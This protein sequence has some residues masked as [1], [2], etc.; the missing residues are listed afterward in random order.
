MTKMDKDA[1]ELFNWKADNYIND[2]ESFKIIPEVC[3]SNIMTDTKLKDFD[4]SFY[5]FNVGEVLRRHRLWLKVLPNVK[6]YFAVKSNPNKLMLKVMISFGMGFDC[7][8]KFELNL[9]NR[10]GAKPENIIYANPCKQPSHILYSKEIN[11]KRSV[12]DSKEELMKMKKNFPHAELVLRIKTDDSTALC[13]LSQKYG[14]AFD[15][16]EDLINYALEL[17]LNVIG[18]SFHVGSGCEDAFTYSKALHDARNL[19]DYAKSVGYNFTLLDIGGG[20]PGDETWRVTFE[21][22]GKVINDSLGKLFPKELFPN[23]EIIAEP[24]R[25]YATKPFT[26]ATS[27]FSKKELNPNGQHDCKIFSYH[28]SEGLL[29]GFNSLFYDHAKLY[30]FTLKKSKKKYESVIWGPSSSELDK[31]MDSVWL[32]ELQIGDWILWKSMGAYTISSQSSYNDEALIYNFIS[33][34]D[35]KELKNFVKS[36]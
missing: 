18:I 21:D 26:L 32:P 11:V 10:L 8:S 36:S 15:D 14:A 7:A 25:F 24:G 3:L 22:I 4:E 9:L 13:R 33:E 16:C 28:V 31:V 23:L 17:G 30:P 19:F 2:D 1:I 27:V 35:M 5:V 20:F 29:G 6:P 12:F 34:A